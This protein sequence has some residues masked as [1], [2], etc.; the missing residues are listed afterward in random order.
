MKWLCITA[1]VL[2]AVG[3]FLI[4]ADKPVLS[5]FKHKDRQIVAKGQNGEICVF[6]GAQM[7]AGSGKQ[8][9]KKCETGITGSYEI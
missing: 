8:Y 6:C 1:G 5:R 9:C 2:F 4:A 3:A 7:P